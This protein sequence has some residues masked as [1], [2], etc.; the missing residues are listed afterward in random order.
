MSDLDQIRRVIKTLIIDIL[1]FVEGVV[2]IITHE[3]FVG[4][5]KMVL[6][7]SITRGRITEIN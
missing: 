3:I 7:I 5:H 2:V 4:T 1:T 6:L